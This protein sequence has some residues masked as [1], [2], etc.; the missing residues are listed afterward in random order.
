MTRFSLDCDCLAGRTDETRKVTSRSS[1]SVYDVSLSDQSCDCPDFVEHRALQ[2]KD[3]F[4]RWCKHII[5]R[6][7]EAGAFVDAN[8][9]QKAIVDHGRG[10]PLGAFLIEL[11]H[12]QEFL[13]T[14]GTSRTWIDVYAKTALPG[15]KLPL[16][17][18]PIAQYGWSIVEKRWS[19]GQAPRGAKNIKQLLTQIEAIIEE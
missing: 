9:W 4:S 7:E 6:A 3:H 16:L 5:W 1:G 11:P 19:Y 17:T 13:T 15:E 12:N 8:P 2:P 18:G 14:V 10:G